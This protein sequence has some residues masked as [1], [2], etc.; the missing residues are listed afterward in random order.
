MGDGLSHSGWIL[1]GVR[2]AFQAP[3][4]RRQ[5]AADVDGDRQHH[6]RIA[7]GSIDGLRRQRSGDQTLSPIR[8]RDRGAPPGFRASR[9]RV[10]RRSDDGETLRRARTARWR[11]SR[12]C[13]G[14]GE[15]RRI[16]CANLSRPQGSP[17]RFIL[18]QAFEHYWY[19]G[20]ARQ[21]W[22]GDDV[23]CRRL[24]A[25]RRASQSAGASHGRRAGS[26]VQ[27]RTRSYEW[28]ISNAER[29]QEDDLMSNE[30]RSAP[31]TRCLREGHCVFN[32]GCS[33]S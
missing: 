32:K 3:R 29:N 4:N 2:E 16:R 18:G 21:K 26:D 25:P 17:V 31:R 1:L 13:S 14:S 33:D 9:R 22:A 24:S 11:T 6:D 19:Y 23:A 5:T 28:N 30:K 10:H 15:A 27:K 12:R 8:F 7:P 20:A